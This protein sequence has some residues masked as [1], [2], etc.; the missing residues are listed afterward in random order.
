ML[1]KV[2]PELSYP[3]SNYPR[4][5]SK[6]SSASLRVG[7]KRRLFSLMHQ[8]FSFQLNTLL[9][10]CE[11]IRMPAGSKVRHG[12]PRRSSHDCWINKL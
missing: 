5:S 12:V 3:Q 9:H 4:E 7:Q 6:S 11:L 10:T 1:I 2:E 8:L